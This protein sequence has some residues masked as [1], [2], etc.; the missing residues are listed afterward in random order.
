MLKTLKGNGSWFRIFS[1][2]QHHFFNR[3]VQF[4]PDFPERLEKEVIDCYKFIIFS[5]D[6]E[7]LESV[8]QKLAIVPDLAISSSSSVNLEITHRK[9]QKG[10]A[11]ETFAHMNGASLNEVMAIGDGGNDKSMLEKAGFS[12]AMGN[13]ADELLKIAD[14]VTSS[15]DEHGFARAV[16]KVL[17]I[18]QCEQIHSKIR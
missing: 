9:A 15:N 7:K 1:G 12:V 18:N 16:E 6:P 10:L 11:L 4:I 14:Y 3:E 17:E 2:I 5:Q 13:A 8:K